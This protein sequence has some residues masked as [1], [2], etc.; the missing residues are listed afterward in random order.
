MV[1]KKFIKRNGKTYGPYVYHSK[2]INGK[3]VSEY[4]GPEENK[5]TKKIWS[6]L[7][8]SIL[9][10][11]LGAIL[12][13]SN[14]KTSGN[15]V[16]DVVGSIT[17]GNL[18]EGK[19]NLVL[20]EGETIPIDS[21]ISIEN[22]GIVQEYPLTE[23]AGEGNLPEGGF[24]VE[25]PIIEYPLISFQ[26]SILEDDQ[27]GTPSEE[28]IPSNNSEIINENTSN[29]TSE[30]ITII[31]ENNSSSENTNSTQPEE[32]INPP[33]PEETINPPQP[34]ENTP[35]APA[36]ETI[37]P[38][39]PTPTEEIPSPTPQNEVSPPAP[40]EE[41]T[42]PE[43][44][45]PTPQE[46]PAP[47]PQEEIPAESNPAPIT[48]GVISN[49]LGTLSKFFAGLITGR[50]TETSSKIYG[51][52]SKDNPFIYKYKGKQINLVQGSVEYNGK[53][54]SDNVLLIEEKGNEVTVKTNYSI[55][56][57]SLGNEYIPNEPKTLS[58]DLSKLS[59]PLT[60]GNLNVKIIY[61]NTEI[62][63]FE[64]EILNKTLNNP[65]E[66]NNITNLTDK[67]FNSSINISTTNIDEINFQMNL[68]EEEKN[69]LTSMLNET[70]FTTTINKYKNRFLVEYSFSGYKLEHSYPGTFSEEKLNENV[71]RDKY[72][73][74][75]DILKSL[76]EEKSKKEEITNLN[77]N[78]SI[79]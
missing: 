78:P 14:S 79:F 27:T 43:E 45:T 26:L 36:E 33:Q 32:T 4:R 77:L 37:I 58:I 24:G 23:L 42:P 66:I 38:E 35:P 41:I 1:Y 46:T 67:I 71:E 61:N 55:L 53:Q 29:E 15:V 40:V 5:N 22:N 11:S 44:T 19:L 56:I 52:T 30:E 28:P 57:D 10:I 17:N 63:S 65:E 7:I 48:G 25:K 16:F 21:V 68:T 39:T 72:L 64:G 59:K 75:K 74:I 12:F 70:D 47:T 34:E 2:R 8:A 62:S 9:I 49:I 73:W 6:I 54:L 69:L 13:F 18:F 60:K 76:S 50:V 31:P 51:E 20:N 3:V